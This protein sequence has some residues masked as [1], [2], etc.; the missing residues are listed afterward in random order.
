M[1]RFII[2]FE[3]NDPDNLGDVTAPVAYCYL[4]SKIDKIDDREVIYLTNSVRSKCDFDNQAVT[5]LNDLVDT[6][7]SADK[8]VKYRDIITRILW[9]VFED[10]ITDKE[11]NYFTAVLDDVA[12]R[13]EY[14]AKHNNCPDKQHII[15]I[16]SPLSVR[17]S[18]HTEKED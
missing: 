5:T 12:F 9:A 1:K 16:D 10:T 13:S 3:E 4:L 8:L 14:D 2:F 7:G 18:K 6:I 15:C 17:P 11:N